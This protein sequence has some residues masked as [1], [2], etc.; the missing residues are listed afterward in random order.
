MQCKSTP[1]VF[2]VGGVH[3]NCTA[4]TI[5]A[6]PECWLKSLLSN[7]K[8]SVDK[9]YYIDR[10][11]TAFPIILN[12]IRGYSI[13]PSMI[14]SQCR[15]SGLSRT[16]FYTQLYEDVTFYA[17]AGLID[18]VE[19]ILYEECPALIKDLSRV[20]ALFE[21]DPLY[22]EKK[23]KLFISIKGLCGEIA[24]NDTGAEDGEIAQKVLKY[25]KLTVNS[26]L[27]TMEDALEDLQEMRDLLHFSGLARGY[28]IGIVSFILHYVQTTFGTNYSTATVQREI[29]Q[30]LIHNP[31]VMKE[32]YGYFRK[33][34]NSP[35]I[36]FIFST[37][38][39]LAMYIHASR[40]TPNIIPATVTMPDGSEGDNDFES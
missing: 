13:K 20:E 31:E 36:N 14:K 28:I 8:P 29:Y 30:K 9:I 33:C 12:Y 26:P 39:S 40:P 16:E 27:R 4:E 1:V 35:G 21:T 18:Q 10:D 11:P 24:D 2:N 17:I 3:F 15:I 23:Q 38:V 37:I 32:L 19:M 22:L 25:S 7:D 5:M 6:M 34:S